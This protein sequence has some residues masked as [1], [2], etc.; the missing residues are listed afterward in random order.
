MANGYAGKILRVNLTTQTVTT[1]DTKQYQQYWGGHAMGSALFWDL[2]KDKTVKFN[3]PG[4]VVTVMTSPAT[5]TM[6]P[7]AGRTEVQGIAPQPF[8]VEFFSRSNFGGRFGPLLKM[9]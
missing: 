4:N 7:C 9:A 6:A 8:P 2:C 1:I 5:G 3:D